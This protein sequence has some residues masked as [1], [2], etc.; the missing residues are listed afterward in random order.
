MNNQLLAGVVINP[1]GTHEVCAAI[2]ELFGRQILLGSQPLNDV[3][4]PRQRNH[5]HSI[6][7]KV[8]AS[9]Q[10][11]GVQPFLTGVPSFDAGWVQET[12]SLVSSFHSNRSNAGLG[13]RMVLDQTHSAGYHLSGALHLGVPNRRVFEKI[14]VKNHVQGCSDVVTGVDK[15]LRRCDSQRQDP[16]GLHP[17]SW[18]LV[19]RRRRRSCKGGVP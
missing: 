6:G 17:T 2:Y 8:D 3:V 1:N 12:L 13:K 14:G 9:H 11:A 18:A 5:S 7:N 10:S 16:W 4:Y 19:S 15:K